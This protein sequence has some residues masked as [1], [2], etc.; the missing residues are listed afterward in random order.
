MPSI[1]TGVGEMTLDLKSRASTPLL[2]QKKRS[3]I[4]ATSEKETLEFIGSN[5]AR[6]F[7]LILNPTVQDKQICCLLFLEDNSWR[8]PHL[9]P[10][11]ILIVARPLDFRLVYLFYVVLSAVMSFFICYIQYFLQ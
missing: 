2:V 5:I 9:M 1:Y 11:F 3:G 6:P 8:N 7:L 4:M 10:Q